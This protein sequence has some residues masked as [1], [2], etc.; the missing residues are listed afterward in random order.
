MSSDEEKR[1]KKLLNNAIEALEKQRDEDRQNKNYVAGGFY[2]MSRKAEKNLRELAVQN[3]TASL[4]FSVIREKMLIGTNAVTISNTAL[5]KLINVHPRTIAR[6]TQYLANHRYIQIIKTGNVN[7]FIVNE[8]VA[9]SGKRGQ[10][11]AVFSSTIV[12]HEAEQDARFESDIGELLNIP[13][14]QPDEHILLGN[15]ACEPPDQL[16]LDL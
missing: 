6:S 11:I 12:A 15:D 14:P 3:R 10:R 9:F 8:R 2:M 5:G 4:V 16:D 7:T 1:L 13:L